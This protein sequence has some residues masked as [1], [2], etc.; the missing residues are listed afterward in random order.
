MLDHHLRKGKHQETPG[1]H[2]LVEGEVA[3]SLPFEIMVQKEPNLN[4][5]PVECLKP[6]S[7]PVIK[8]R[9]V[10]K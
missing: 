4:P 1:L 6:S 7:P 10:K 2:G 8:D 9:H 5:Q 3:I